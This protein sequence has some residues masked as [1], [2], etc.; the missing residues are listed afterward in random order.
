MPD[1]KFEYSRAINQSYLHLKTEYILERVIQDTKY[2]FVSNT[3]LSSDFHILWEKL[4]IKSESIHRDI[5][6]LFEQVFGLSFIL[7]EE[8]DRF[9]IFSDPLGFHPLFC[10]LG[11]DKFI[12]SDDQLNVIKGLSLN[13]SLSEKS[14]ASYINNGHLIADQSW[15]KEV[16]RM[17]AA[18]HYILRKDSLKLTHDYYWTWSEV[19]KNYGAANIED[20]IDSFG[21]SFRNLNSNLS[22]ILGLSGGLES[23]WIA[24]FASILEKFGTYTFAE[25]ETQDLIIAQKV[26][27]ILSVKH[28]HINIETQHISHRLKSFTQMQGMVHLGHIHEGNSLDEFVSQYDVL[29]HGFYGGYEFADNLNCKVNSQLANSLFS[30]GDENSY[31]EP[32]F[33]FDCIDP[34]IANYKI[35]NQAA[36]TL[37]RL[38]DLTKV[39]LPFYNMKWI[40]V[41][42]SIDD[43]LQKHKKFYLEALNKSMSHE[44][45]E[46]PW[47]KTGIPIKYIALNSFI[48]KF[49]I[50]TIREKILNILGKT[51][52]FINYAKF[53]VELDSMLSDYSASQFCSENNMSLES[54]EQKWRILS[55]LVWK[56]FLSRNEN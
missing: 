40:C 19:N 8:I 52:H 3:V 11:F 49:K 4:N 9:H 1:F 28:S 37:H 2:Y 46:V 5:Y 33:D 23:R 20:Y 31:T 53:N 45:C 14:I 54:R 32:Y 16:A 26:A 17:K 24:S 44:L 38:N 30:I 41:N 56:D 39:V 29:M 55:L 15:F 47:Q 25:S 18:S 22:Y 34:F 13:M 48:L 12:C 42:Y 50:H 27:N 6:S 7:I 51:S 10:G 35:R 21:L 43:N 36:F